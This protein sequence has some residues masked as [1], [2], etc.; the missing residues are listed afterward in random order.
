MSEQWRMQELVTQWVIHVLFCFFPALLF[1]TPLIQLGVCG[2]AV[3]CKLPC[4]RQTLF[5]CILKQKVASG[6]NKL[7][8]IINDWRYFSQVKKYC[9]MPVG[10]HPL[11]S[12]LEPSLC[13]HF[14]DGQ[15]RWFDLNHDWITCGDLIWEKKIWFES[16]LIWFIIRD[17]IC[18]L[19]KSQTA[20]IWSAVSPLDYR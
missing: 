14:S 13:P 16:V 17:L 2:S 20:P 19:S 7:P 15:I 1:L 8:N 11:I 4:G 10:I 5:F 3:A 6:C 18:N 9:C 12:L